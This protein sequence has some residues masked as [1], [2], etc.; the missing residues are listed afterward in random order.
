[1]FIDQKTLVIGVTGGVGT[2]K[3]VF[4]QELGRLGAY[5]IDADKIAKKIVNERSD[6][7][8]ELKKTFGDQIFDKCGKLKRKSLGRIV[9]ADQKKLIKLNR[10]IQPFLLEA[11]KH[12]IVRY[13]NEKKKSFIAVDMAII[14]ESGIQDLFDKIIVV[15]AS[16]E[17][18]RKWL[19]EKREWNYKEIDDRMRRQINN[20]KKIERADIVIDN[21]GTIEDLIQSA[22]QVFEELC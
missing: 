17:N 21:Q 12:Q 9:F 5:I 15:N 2:G 18:R 3:T 14:Y 10:I 19:L 6:I 20:K 22:R 8:Y 4:S 11:I 16:E 7:K 1:M 13:K